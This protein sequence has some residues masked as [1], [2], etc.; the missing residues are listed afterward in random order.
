[1]TGSYNK[2]TKAVLFPF[3][4]LRVIKRAAFCFLKQGLKIF[5]E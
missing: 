3:G 1:M 2:E 4:K 5:I